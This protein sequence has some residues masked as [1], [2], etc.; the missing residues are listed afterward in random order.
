MENFALTEQVINHYSP[1]SHF[2]FVSTKAHFGN[3]VNM[4]VL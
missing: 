3:F 2:F 4:A 1:K